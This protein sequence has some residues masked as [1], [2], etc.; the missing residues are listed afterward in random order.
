[1]A[2]EGEEP[3]EMRPCMR[4]ANEANEPFSC[5]VGRVCVEGACVLNQGRRAMEP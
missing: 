4:R 5:D 2:E 1:M 3:F